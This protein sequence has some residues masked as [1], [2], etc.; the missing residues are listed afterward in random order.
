MNQ[1][2]EI[3]N[4]LDMPLTRTIGRAVSVVKH[5]QLVN[6]EVNTVLTILVTMVVMYTLWNDFQV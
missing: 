6:F 3:N 5:R 1:R 4:H 2:V